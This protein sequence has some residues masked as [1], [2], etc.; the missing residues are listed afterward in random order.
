MP[1]PKAFKDKTHKNQEKLNLISDMLKLRSDITFELELT[2]GFSQKQLESRVNK[3]LSRSGGYRSQ[4]EKELKLKKILIMEENFGCWF[5]QEER[6]AI[7]NLCRDIYI[8]LKKANKIYPSYMAEF[9]ERRLNLDRAMSSLDALNGEL[10]YIAESIPADKNRYTALVLR[11]EK[12]GNGVKKLRKS[13]NRF[14]KH[15]NGATSVS[16]AKF[17]NVNDNGNANY[18][19]ASNSNG[20]RPDFCN[21][22]KA[23]GS[24]D[25]EIQKGEVVPSAKA[26]K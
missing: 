26:D 22:N 20:V 21:Y 19:N 16:A 2:F 6:K 13:D 3:L 9:E 18:N 14:L 4:E 12:L 17:A 15:I 8:N 25:V 24:P 1:K 11:V 5:I 7:L 23:T 10:Q